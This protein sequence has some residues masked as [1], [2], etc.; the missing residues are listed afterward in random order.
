M[1]EAEIK[2]IVGDASAVLPTGSRHICDPAPTDTDED[3]LVYA[4]RSLVSELE[5][6][7]FV[8]GGAYRESPTSSFRSWRRDEVNLIVTT[9]L[10]FYLRFAAATAW[11]K[12]MN[13]LSKP[14]RVSLFNAITHGDGPLS[15][16]FAA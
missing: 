1:T 14:E 4:E 11:A 5:S 2:A 12:E 16:E 10:V 13:V 8:A 15:M 9:S 3:W 7:G 6:A